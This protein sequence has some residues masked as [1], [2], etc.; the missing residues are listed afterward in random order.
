MR[1][2]VVPKASLNESYFCR[3]QAAGLHNLNQQSAAHNVLSRGRDP[4]KEDCENVS[5]WGL[6]A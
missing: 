2:A 6:V 3:I 1:L 5:V 4:A